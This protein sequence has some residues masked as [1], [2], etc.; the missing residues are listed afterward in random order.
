MPDSLNHILQYALEKAR[1]GVFP[2]VHNVFEQ[3]LFD[4]LRLEVMDAILDKQVANNFHTKDASNKIGGNLLSTNSFMDPIAAFVNLGTGKAVAA[5]RRTTK[6]ENQL[7]SQTLD[8]EAKRVTGKLISPLSRTYSAP[9]DSPSNQ[10]TQLNRKKVFL[11][12][13]PVHSAVTDVM[14]KTRNG[15]QRQDD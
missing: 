4:L 8:A 2:V 15:G 10:M 13:V 6:M 7:K 3:K 14:E 9:S 11:V 1:T 12:T 5:K